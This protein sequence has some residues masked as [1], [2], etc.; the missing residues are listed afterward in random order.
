MT[1][2]NSFGP[3]QSAFGRSLY[4]M[5][6]FG[7]VIF[8]DKLAIDF[9]NA[10]GITDATQQQAITKLVYDL[11]INRLWDKMTAIYPFIGG[12]ASTHKWNLKD[13]QDT[14]AAFRLSFLGGWTHNNN[15]AQPNGSNGY[16][17]TFINSRNNLTNTSVHFSVYSRTQPVGVECEI[18]NYDLGTSFNQLRA[19]GNFVF[20]TNAISFTT[21][22]DA[23]G[24]WL[25]TKRD[26]NDREGYF[27]GI[28][29]VTNTT[30]D[31]ALFPNFN[32]FISARSNGGTPVLY[33]NKQLAF[34]SIGSGFTDAEA[35]TLYT[36]VQDFQT[37]LSRNV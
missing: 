37:T 35:L 5:Q 8:P 18:G 7:S 2:F 32:I 30:N 29:Q 25:A 27:N 23:R 28:S 10:A 19:A 13:P 31:A 6:P 15:G 3:R 9:I 1:C 11:V 34:A 16:A 14:D 22:T 26:N 20:G 36:A 24:F 4:P 21:T 33:S 17:N 12:T